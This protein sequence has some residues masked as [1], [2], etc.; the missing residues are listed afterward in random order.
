VVV[1]ALLLGLAVFAGLETR[2]SQPEPATWIRPTEGA[3]GVDTSLP[4][5]WDARRG[6]H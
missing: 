6:N 2:T 1:S 5:E 4:F 3:A